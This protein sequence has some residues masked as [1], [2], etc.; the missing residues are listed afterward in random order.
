MPPKRSEKGIDFKMRKIISYILSF[1]LMLL[2]LLMCLLVIAK[3]TILDEKYLISQLEETRYY[4]RMNG[5]IIEQFKNYTIQSGLSDNVLEN[6]FTEDKLKNDINSVV[7]SLYTGKNLKIDTTEIQENLKENVLEEVSKEGKTVDFEDE[8]MVEYI[9]AIEM[10]YESQVSYSTNA[11]NSIGENFS[12][13]IKLASTAQNIVTVALVVMAILLILINIKQIIGLNYIA[14]SSIAS[15]LFILIS[16]ILLDKSTDLKNIMI[17]NQA[18][19]QVI[20]NTI[21]DILTKVTTAGIV[22][23]IIGLISSIL[24]NLILKKVSKSV[25]K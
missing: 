23:L 2:I 17:I 5:E 4:E 1:I 22:L 9:K 19:S 6:L 24:Y 16:K 18:T 25:E 15:G 12:K 20:Q 21:N 13:I 3:S 10:A 11:V 14:I 8:A 7:N